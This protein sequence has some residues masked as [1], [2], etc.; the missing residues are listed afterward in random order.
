M[1]LSLSMSWSPFCVWAC[2]QGC[3]CVGLPRATL[4]SKNSSSKAIGEH[5]DSTVPM[6]YA[7]TTEIG[8][9]MTSGRDNLLPILDAP[10]VERMRPLFG[11]N[12]QQLSEL[13][14]EFSVPAY[15]VRQLSQ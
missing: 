13:L 8:V 3:C 2:C 15:R 7:D 4:A 14:Q 1:F 5:C 10:G 11:L 6:R 9:A 12:N